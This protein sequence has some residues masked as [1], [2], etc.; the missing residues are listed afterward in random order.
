MPPTH[1]QTAASSGP[2]VSLDHHR[3]RKRLAVLLDRRERL[4]RIAAER[5]A[6][7]LPDAEEYRHELA[8]VEQAIGHCAPDLYDEQLNEWVRLDA[9]RI[10]VA[11]QPSS[12]C[13]I[14]RSLAI[15]AVEPPGAA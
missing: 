14:C 9:A 11:D 4:A 13:G 2:V 6:H 5:E 7:E 1:P 12:E 10:H 15:A 3:E 8:V